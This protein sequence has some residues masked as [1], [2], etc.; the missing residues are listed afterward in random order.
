MKE[1]H[2][3]AIRARSKNMKG[4][5]GAEEKKKLNIVTLAVQDYPWIIFVR[6]AVQTENLIHV[7]LC[8]MISHIQ[9]LM[10]PPTINHMS[11]LILSIQHLKSRLEAGKKGAVDYSAGVIRPVNPN[12]KNRV[13]VN[14]RTAALK[15]YSF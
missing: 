13:R 7:N 5:C 14:V 11:I 2:Q 10:A 12:L 15:T 8:P 3:A 6:D 1:H 4:S 9:I